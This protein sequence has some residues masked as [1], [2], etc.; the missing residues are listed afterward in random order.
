MR[1]KRGVGPESGEASSRGI[2]VVFE[3]FFLDTGKICNNWSL[4]FSEVLWGLQINCKIVLDILQKPPGFHTTTREPKRAVGTDATNTTKIPR[5][6]P[7]REKKSENGGGGRGKKGRN[8]GLSGGG[9]SRGG[10]PKA[11]VPKSGAR[12]VGPRRVGVRKV[13]AQKYKKWGPEGG[14]PAGWGAQ[15]FT[16]FSPL[17]PLF[18]FFLPLLVVVSWNSGGVTEGHQKNPRND[19]RER[20][21]E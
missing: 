10:A 14:G 12:I 15:N 20:K 16:L 18:S 2:S 1:A 8:F 19:P 5:E 13:Q 7:Q 21:K 4:T 9:G 3:A 6:D 11:G 17:P